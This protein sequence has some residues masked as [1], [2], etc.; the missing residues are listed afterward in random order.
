MKSF[1]QDNDIKMCL[2]HIEGKSV[3][4]EVFIKTLKNEAYEYMTSI[5]KNVCINKLDDIFDKCNNAYMRKLLC[6]CN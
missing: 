5:L 6:F 4:A 1:L 2:I 3:I